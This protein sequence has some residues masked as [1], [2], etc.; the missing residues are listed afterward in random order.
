[1]LLL[2]PSEFFNMNELD[3]VIEAFLLATMGSA[4]IELFTL[5]DELICAELAPVA[6]ICA[7]ACWSKATLFNENVRFILRNELMVGRAHEG[8]RAL[9]APAALF[10]FSGV[11]VLL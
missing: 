5:I 11:E 4:I 6:A 10:R 8:G 3:D 2:L 7:A 9:R 1:L